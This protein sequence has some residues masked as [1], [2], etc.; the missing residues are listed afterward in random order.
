MLNRQRFSICEAKVRDIFMQERRAVMS[1]TKSELIN[2]LGGEKVLDS[3]GILEA[4][5]RDESFVKPIRARF[6]VKPVNVDEVQ[7]LVQWAGKERTPLVPLS[8]GPPRFRGDTVPGVPEAVIVD[9][10]GM[11][12][13]ISINL[14]H[15]MVIVEPGV[16]YS[17]LQPA[18]AKEGLRL[19][20]PLAPRENKSVI[21]SVLEIEPRLNPRQ[22]WNYVD[23]FRCAEVI[24]GDGQKLWTGDAAGGPLDLETQWSQNK[25]QITGSGPG[26]TDFHRFLTAAQGSMG[27]VTWAS[28]RCQELPQIHKLY[29]VPAKNPAGLQ[30]FVYKILRLSFGDELMLMNGTY[31]ANLLGE[32]PEQIKRI[33]NEMPP[34]MA[35]IGI[36]G[37]SILPEERVDQQEKD[38]TEIAQQYGLNLLSSAAGI[39]SQ[40]ILAK[41]LNPCGKPF[42]KQRYKGCFQDIFFVSTLDKA[43]GFIA[44][45]NSVAEDE[46]YPTSDIGVYIQPQHK[47][48]S[49][50]I[51][52]NLPYSPDQADGMQ[53]FYLRAST[54]LLKQ[55]AF[56]SRPYG[57]WGEM[58]FNKDAQTVKFLSKIKGIFDPNN[59]MNPA[60]LCY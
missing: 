14:R 2:I 20:T 47:G 40:E 57:I 38:I 18:L 17:E 48:T 5:S 4:Y 53:K 16:T 43:Q 29:L 10:S 33:K 3:P 21:A 60:K 25:W 31:L 13:I 7:K 32:S 24:F 49:C 54:E 37:Y 6:V 50:H 35:L 51:E 23:P 55:G 9:L 59:I 15:R 36:A 41:I 56:Y 46:V 8:S 11:K 22:Q 27:I 44:A 30:E 42:W 28:M 58:A 12:K 34:W 39:P 52:F 26:F 19:S 45:M 1:D